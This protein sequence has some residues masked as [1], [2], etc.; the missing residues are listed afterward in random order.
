LVATR[1]GGAEGLENLVAEDRFVNRGAFKTIENEWADALE[2]K[3]GAAVDVMP[4]YA[5]ESERPSALIANYTISSEGQPKYTDYF[6]TTNIDLRGDEFNVEQFD[7][8]NEESAA[9][10]EFSSADGAEL[11][12]NEY[13][14]DYFDIPYSVTVAATELSSEETKTS[15][16]IETD[17]RESG[18]E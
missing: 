17:I 9:S 10:S 4:Y 3:A 18:T 5:D 12:G 6:S 15:A 2:D 7:L 8:T 13:D 14:K 11:L 1:F 16:D